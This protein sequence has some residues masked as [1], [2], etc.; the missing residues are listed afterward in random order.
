MM[1]LFTATRIPS[2]LPNKNHLLHVL[3]VTSSILHAFRILARFSKTAHQ[4]QTYHQ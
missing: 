1:M 2:F 3:V 4:D